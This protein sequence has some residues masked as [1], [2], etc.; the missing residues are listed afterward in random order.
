MLLEDA[1]GLLDLLLAH[2]GGDLAFLAVAA[3]LDAIAQGS[4]DAVIDTSGY[5][6]RCVGASAFCCGFPYW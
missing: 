6:P 1:L 5:V 4:W 3:R 2:L